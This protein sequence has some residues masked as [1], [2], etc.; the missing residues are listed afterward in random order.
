MKNNINGDKYANLINQKVMEN[1]RITT[2]AQHQGTL[3]GAH[4]CGLH[5]IVP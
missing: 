2:S 1:V 4:T 5:P 3:K